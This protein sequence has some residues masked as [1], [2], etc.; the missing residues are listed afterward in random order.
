MF[1]AEMARWYLINLSYSNT[2]FVSPRHVS[3]SLENA[4][5]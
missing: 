4:I 2:N 3:I 1:F 5:L